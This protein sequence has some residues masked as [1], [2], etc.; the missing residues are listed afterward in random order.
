M[1][2]ITPVIK[3]DIHKI[4]K[5]RSWPLHWSIKAKCIDKFHDTVTERITEALQMLGKKLMV[6]ARLETVKL[7]EEE[8]EQE[9]EQEQEITD[10]D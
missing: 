3:S 5:L 9:Q 10:S 1:D 4:V 8:Q 6:P 2:V 7:D